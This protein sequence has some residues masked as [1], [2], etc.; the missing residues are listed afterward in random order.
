M[1]GIRQLR[2][3]GFIFLI[4]YVLE[5]VLIPLNR[6]SLNHNPSRSTMIGINT[7]HPVIYLTY[8]VLAP[9]MT[10]Y[11][12]RFLT[13]RNSSDFYHSIPHTRTCLYISYIAAI[14]TWVGVILFVSSG[15]SVC[16]FSWL[17]Y[18]SVQLSMVIPYIIGVFT[19]SIGVVCGVSLAQCITGTVLSNIIVSGI[20]FFFPRLL[21]FAITENILDKTYGLIPGEYFMP[22]LNG[23]YNLITTVFFNRNGLS[24]FTKYS[25]W[26]YTFILAIIYFAAGLY[27]FNKRHSENAENPASSRW[28]QAVYRICITLAFCLIPICTI[29][30]DYLWSTNDLTGIFTLYC[31]AVVI[32]FLFEIITTKTV[33]NLLKVVPGLIVIAV[34]NIGIIFFINTVSDYQLN[35]CPESSEVAYINSQTY[36]NSAI[37][38]S[39][40]KFFLVAPSDNTYR[41]SDILCENIK[42]DDEKIIAATLE[43]LE[44]DIEHLQL[45]PELSYEY[46]YR[47]SSLFRTFAIHMKNGRTYYRR[48]NVNQTVASS[49]KLYTMINSYLSDNL[50]YTESLEHLPDFKD[51]TIN[52]SDKNATN[53][54]KNHLYN[55]F[56]EDYATFST[57]EKVNF[58]AE[59]YLY[60]RYDNDFN[61]YNYV[62]VMT[63]YFSFKGKMCYLDIPITPELPNTFKT[64]LNYYYDD[65]S[66]KDLKNIL[67]HI[68]DYVLEIRE[69]FDISVDVQGEQS[70]DFYYS[71]TND[72]VECVNT[73]HQSEVSDIF[74]K[75]SEYI[76]D[77]TAEYT[78]S[79][80]ECD[81]YIKIVLQSYEYDNY[82]DN[83]ILMPMTYEVSELYK[84]L[85]DSK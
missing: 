14:L 34:L 52:L 63:V 29:C 83:T 43:A 74:N 21:T 26:I 77:T 19:A 37:L 68:E 76:P 12:F 67:S 38:E 70:I 1:E 6:A 31:I 27:L 65:D 41:F 22:A 36:I 48:I 46:M 54:Q 40:S 51:T 75:L 85:G 56:L 33:R 79:L 8:T 15:I 42:I 60:R 49:S 47:D 59:N 45:N 81:S 11:L 9:I 61:Y 18:Y 25:S 35:F 16:I 10:L 13:K 64:Y 28:L 24:D 17:P 4:I 44:S 80:M 69:S 82:A 72:S 50:K 39:E 20:I 5:A 58:I 32:Y 3:I 62:D 84:Q 53:T 30:Q 71:Y 73:T 7:M 23:K 78:D 55:A 2:I 66:L 57:E